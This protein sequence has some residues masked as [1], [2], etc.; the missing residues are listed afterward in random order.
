MGC[1]PSLAIDNSPT[2]DFSFSGIKTAVLRYTQLHNMH[3]SIE[4]RRHTLAANPN[5]KPSEALHLLDQQ[6]LDL[7]ASFQSAVVGNLLRQTF[8]AAEHFGARSLVVSG[9]VAANSELR[10]RFTAE[11]DR[12]GIPAAF[13]SLALSTDNAAMIAAAAWPRLLAEDFAPEDL[14]AT[15]QLRL[16]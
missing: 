7:I 15:P 14:T 1:L 8:A 12:R 4:S 10:R 13:P 2:F 3:D 11:A 9:G 6:T 16:G 5:L